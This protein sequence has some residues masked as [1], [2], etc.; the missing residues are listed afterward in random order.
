VQGVLCTGLSFPKYGTAEVGGQTVVQRVDD[1]AAHWIPAVTLNLIAKESPAESVY[2]MV[3]IGITHTGEYLAGTL[4]AG[5]R[6]PNYGPSRSGGLLV[7]RVRDPSTL[8]PGDVVTG[9]AQIDADLKFRDK[10]TLNYYIGVQ[11]AFL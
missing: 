10:V 11:R 5:I 7:T 6:I 4:G 1:D 3:Q 9:T 8:K 2:P